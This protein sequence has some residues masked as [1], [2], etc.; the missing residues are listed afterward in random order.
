MR[1]GQQ[2][3]LKSGLPDLEGI[4]FISPQSLGTTPSPLQRRPSAATFLGAV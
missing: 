2:H 3:P 4:K 1:K